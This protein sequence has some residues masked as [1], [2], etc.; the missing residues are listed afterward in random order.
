MVRSLSN[1]LVL[2][3]GGLLS[4]EAIC[5]DERI[6][7]IHSRLL[8]DLGGYY[9]RYGDKGI[10]TLSSTMPEHSRQF[11]LFH[12]IHH[13]F[14]H[15][16]YADSERRILPG[17]ANEVRADEFAILAQCPNISSRATPESIMEYYRVSCLVALMRLNIDMI[18]RMIWG[19]L[20]RHE[21]LD[22]IGYARIAQRAGI[23]LLV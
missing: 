9:V 11:F 1:Y 16:I 21:E 19:R 5:E 3:Y 22:K 17:K 10:I 2:R 7:I 12:E 15:G 20:M 14:M 18:A 23:N 13:H 6:T 4:A 8:G